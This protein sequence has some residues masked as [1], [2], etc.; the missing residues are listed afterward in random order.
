MA[1]IF[2]CSDY[3]DASYV[4][5]MAR[6][7]Y[8]IVD[9]PWPC[10]P[11]NFLFSE[12]PHAK[13]VSTSS[14]LSMLQVCGLALSN[15]HAS[16]LVLGPLALFV[17]WSLS[18][19]SL[20]SLQSVAELGGLWL[21]L[22]LSPYVA[23]I[24]AAH[25]PKQGSWGDL[26]SVRGFLRHIL[27]QEYG[28][29]R[30]GLAVP[31]AEDAFERIREY[32]IDSSSQT[33]HVGPPMALLGMG[34]ALKVHKNV[35]SGKRRR[36]EK[37]M[38]TFGIALIAGWAFYVIFWHSVL[39]NIS[40]QH[41]MGR[42]VHARFWMQPNLLLCLTAG[43]G[44]G[45]VAN[46]AAAFLSRGFPLPVGRT[47]VTAIISISLPLGVAAGMLW[48]QWDVMDRG[49]WSGRSHGWT[50]HLYGQVT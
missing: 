42:A 24:F 30:L 4:Q 26:S 38:R 16:A 37:N 2:L 34:W 48:L 43:G 25:Q 27:R 9:F 23:L 49:A 19:K 20:L 44:F 11:G 6:S 40:L 36:E 45:L 8:C 46:A 28:T 33:M 13:P 10:P 47:F 5:G 41:P 7:S 39:S 15:Q 21:P 50:M 12:K 22:G 35:N 17:L 1:E 29:L 32:L 3:V 14:P 31:N 18:R